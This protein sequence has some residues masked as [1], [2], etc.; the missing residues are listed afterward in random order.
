MPR[1]KPRA[2]GADDVTSR[3]S[4]AGHVIDEFIDSRPDEA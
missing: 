2:I 4:G 1:R 3:M